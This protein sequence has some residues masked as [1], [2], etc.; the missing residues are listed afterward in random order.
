M[1]PQPLI[2]VKDVEVSS[3]WYQRALGLRSGHGGAEYER[4]LSGDH[5]VL[6][7]HRWDAHDHPHLGREDA[8]PCG[9]GV[10]LW[11]ETADVDAAHARAMAQGVE[12]LEPLHVNASAQHREFWI[13]DPDGYVVV[14]AG[15]PGE[16]TGRSAGA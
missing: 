10:L 16:V 8:G 9:N 5:L 1:T 3:E 14:V 12:V 6:Q 13:R 15:R 2:A 11:F 4:L 7:L